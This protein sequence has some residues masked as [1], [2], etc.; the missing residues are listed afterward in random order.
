MKAILSVLFLMLIPHIISAQQ[1]TPDLRDLSLEELLNVPVSSAARKETTIREAPATSYVITQQMIRERGYIYLF[2]ALRD[3]PGIDTI[4]MGGLYGPILLFRGLDTPENN[5]VLLLIDGI[6]DNNLSAGT[7]QIYMQYRLHNVERIEIVYGP[8][9]ALYGANAMAGVINIVSKKGVDSRG[10]SIQGTG[11]SW[12]PEFRRTGFSGAFATSDV[13]EREDGKL[14]Y[15]GTFHM[16]QTEGSDLKLDGDVARSD[17]PSNPAAAS[18]YFSPDHI[19]SGEIGTFMAQGRV[20]YDKFGINAGGHLWRHNGGQGT[21]GHEGFA[22]LNGLQNKPDL[23]NFQNATV[24]LEKTDSIRASI[25]NAFQFVYRDTRIRSNSYDAYFTVPGTGPDGAGAA[26]S[27]GARYSRPD[28]SYKFDDNVTWKIGNG[29]HLTAGGSFEFQRVSDYQLAYGHSFDRQ[30]LVD[31]GTEPEI[32]DSRLYSNDIISGYAEHVW[33]VGKG[34]DITTGVRLDAFRLQGDRT[35]FFFGTRDYDAFGNCVPDA[36]DCKTAEEAAA[37]G[38]TE[39]SS[40]YYIHSPYDRTRTSVNPRIGAVYSLPEKN[41][42]LKGM[43]GEGFRMPTVRELFSVT[44][45]RFSSPGL[46]PE[47]IRTAEFSATYQMKNR[48][49]IEVDTFYTTADDQI[50]LSSASVKRPGRTSFLNQFQNV[51]SVHIAGADIKLQTRATDSVDV[52][53]SYS[54]L[55]PRNVDFIAGSVSHN[56]DTADPNDSSLSVPRQATH[57]GTIGAAIYFQNR[58]VVITPRIN[59]VGERRQIITSPIQSVD[60]Y[61]SLN[62]SLL[63]R[64]LW[65]K[66][67][68]QL[69]AYNLTNSDI[70]DPGFRTANKFNDFPAVHPEPGFHWF[71][72][73]GY[74][75]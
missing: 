6:V 44:G 38:A 12:D 75:F 28:H 37:A 32:D 14:S 29:M 8:A 43:Y 26:G 53:G 19:G 46:G 24:F 72:N 70:L 27:A 45:S 67:F 13:M 30:R 71:M 18:Y 42:T 7:A 41:L 54:I 35:P 56:P 74:D 68:L 48:G 22:F 58:N 57:K 31:R 15:T 25:S 62:I 39:V 69:T 5:K 33:H 11:I 40:I 51:G 66:G 34:F 3:A 55:R 10:T 59:W 50:Q 9:S 61:G 65:Q 63:W 60:S 64:G 4:W 52:F 49:F 1:D 20:T 23:W 16:I 73:F 17:Q 2:D 36:P 21:Y 47:K